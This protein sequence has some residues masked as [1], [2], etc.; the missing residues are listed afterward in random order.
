[1]AY[2]MSEL[3]DASGALRIIAQAQAVDRSTSA[4]VRSNRAVL[5]T[6]LGRHGEA[7]TE[8]R[9]A[10]DELEAVESY[11]LS[12][13]LLNRGTL[14][15]TLGQLD[16]ALRDTERAYRLGRSQHN[17]AMEFMAK[18]NLGYIKFLAGDLP[19]ALDAM[20]EA[21]AQAP[22][23][24][25]G[26]PAL[27][28]AR[29]L[30]AAGMFSEAQESV[31]R[32]LHAFGAHHAQADLV[33]ALLASGE[34]ALLRGDQ[35]TAR[36]QARKAE[37]IS[38]RREHQGAALLARLLS[39]RADAI[40]FD[41]VRSSRITPPTR[42]TLRTAVEQAA[43]LADAL[44]QAG[45]IEDAR[46]ARLVQADARV[47]LADLAGAREAS[48]K[49]GEGA[50][51]PNLGVRLHHRLVDA[52]IALASGNR[53]ESLAQIAKGLDDLANFMSRFGSQDMQAASS[54]HGG[55]LARTG[56]R[57]ALETGE[58]AVILP[59]LE[60]SRAAT[61]RLP[62]IRPP[63]DPQLVEELAKLRVAVKTARAATLA[64]R[65]DR[66]L[67]REI[68]EQRARIRA[69][70]W[71]TGGAKGKAQR[72]MTMT[73]VQR[74]LREHE[75]DTT[76]LA[77]FRGQG[78]VHALVV[79]ARKAGYRVLEDRAV[80]ERRLARISADL[81]LLAAPRIG[82]PVRAVAN[83]SLQS[84][85]KGLADLLVDP[86]ADLLGP[87]RL[88]V[89]VVGRLGTTPWGLLPGLVGRP[90]SVTPSITA[91]LALP[92]D[93]TPAH[94]RGVLAVAG[95]DVRGGEAEALAVGERHPGSQVLIGEKATGE[96]VLANI[97]GGGLLHIAAHG[98]HVPESP[99]FSA[100][101]LADGPLF[102]YDI[103]PNPTL[104]SHVVLSSCD[105]GQSADQPGGEPLGLAAAL[106]RSGVRTVVAGVS[107]INDSVAATVMTAYHDRLL[108]GLDPAAA[109]AAA[110]EVAGDVPAPLTLFGA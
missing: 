51:R 60:R 25:M 81:D 39:L 84:G 40:A 64:G 37:R 73:S 35:V 11:D 85:L 56:L 79:T 38:V 15:M 75:P 54:V 83:R 7:L 5:L 29:V 20:A 26:V 94:E 74:H 13:T 32:A 67:E 59:W 47:L 41:P 49:A 22:D 30:T 52:R 18:H 104:P 99:M 42:A 57:T 100:V 101:L 8:F 43:E 105:V 53:H 16:E 110:L 34:L 70:T 106:L 96:A 109:L 45:L 66:S 23:A 93:A 31:E 103:A 46:T 82:A 1:M 86:V 76:V 44:D 65:T 9:L 72:P 50:R 102:G 92:P 14:F 55:A 61:T 91:G 63:N 71:T 87:G 48:A 24:A 27:D 12:M 95:P 28:R 88:R 36:R 2:Q 108:E 90:I 21:S 58:P 97:P 68:V 89:A 107:R 17:G 19:G 3:G 80:V 77:Y 62:A 69:R 4:M 98:H 78:K 6:K 10:V 33:E